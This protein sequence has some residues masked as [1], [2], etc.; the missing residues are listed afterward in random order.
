MSQTEALLEPVHEIAE[1]S[2]Y[3]VRSIKLGMWIFI[4][5]DACTFGAFLFG[6]GYIRVGNANWGAPFD[7]S[8]ILNATLMTF[9]LL[10]S[11]F[12]MLAAVRAAQSGQKARAVRFVMFT[13]L[14][15]TL[16]AAMHL[17]EW[18][19]MF[20]EGWSLSTNPTGGAA[21]FGAAF[22]SI[23]GMHLLHVI[24]GV[25]VLLVI[26]RGFSRERYDSVHLETAGLYW[27]FVDLVWMF[28]FPLMYLMNA[29]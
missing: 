1:E 15:G 20:G 17:R 26:A 13:A 2:P 10:A 16:F 7:F 3:G 5:S 9:V 14:L 25:I 29:H 4:I 22:F 6:Y 18:F 27:H 28:V 24:S 8:T 21:Q 12:T 19:K 23:T 11:S